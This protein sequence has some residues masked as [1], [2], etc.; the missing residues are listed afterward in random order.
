MRYVVWDLYLYVVR[1]INFNRLR[2]YVSSGNDYFHTL[3]AGYRKNNDTKSIRKNII[4][5]CEP[6]VTK[7]IHFK[8]V[9]S[10]SN[11]WKRKKIELARLRFR[12]KFHAAD[13]QCCAHKT[14]PLLR[15][16]TA[17]KKN[18]ISLFELPY[19]KS[20]LHEITKVERIEVNWE[21]NKN[22]SLHCR[23]RC[24]NTT[25]LRWKLQYLTFL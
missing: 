5:I 16:C 22:C 25:N 2:R 6:F 24:P 13:L 1:K 11:R 23:K 17:L 8:I 20:T 14:W 3:R 4:Q 18:W 15:H 21:K 12:A 10:L 7:Y 9:E 19:A